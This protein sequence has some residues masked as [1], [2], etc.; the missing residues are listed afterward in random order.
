MCT[1]DNCKRRFKYK[2]SSF[3]LLANYIPKPLAATSVATRIGALPLRKSAKKI[4][5]LQVH[6]KFHETIVT[7]TITSH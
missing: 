1:E 7:T 4:R 2:R 3:S 6:A 5:V